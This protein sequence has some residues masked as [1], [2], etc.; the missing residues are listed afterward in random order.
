MAFAK[1]S[2]WRLLQ[3]PLLGRGKSVEVTVGLN[4]GITDVDLLVD[5]LSLCREFPTKFKARVAPRLPTFHPKVIF[6]RFKDGSGFAIVGS[7][8]LTGGGQR[9]NVECGAFLTHGTDLK[10][11]ESWYE[12]LESVPL[13]QEIIDA[14]RP[15]NKRARDREDESE[16]S[17]ELT[18]LLRAGRS[19]WYGDLLAAEFTDFLATGPGQRSLQSRIRGARQIKKALSMPEFDFNR[20]GFREFYETPA[21]GKIRPAHPELLGKIRSL[22]R[23]MRFLTAG[24]LDARRFKLVSGGKYHVSGFGINQISKVLTVHGRRRWPVLNERMRTTLRHF[25]Y[26][27]PGT[28][29]GYLQFA[30]DMRDLLGRAGSVDFWAFDAF[31]THKY[32]EVEH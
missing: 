7:G 6:A 22:Q 5:W 17:P 30:R 1:A 15:L 28:A 19:D 9:H 8:N 31:C 23:A 2:G 25:G 26:R 3:E 29:E 4:F 13:K 14:Y 11:L 10:R 16:V 27:I 12:R 24:P 21:F 32:D 20:I 18:E